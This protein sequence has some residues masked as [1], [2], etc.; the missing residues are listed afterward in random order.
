MG[1][2]SSIGNYIE[3]SKFFEE[4]GVDTNNPLAVENELD[5]L[6]SDNPMHSSLSTRD[7]EMQKDAVQNSGHVDTLNDSIFS[8]SSSAD[9]SLSSDSSWFSSSDSG[10]DSSSS[11][12]SDSGWFSSGDSD[13]D[14]ND[15]GWPW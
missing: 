2:L 10:R 8:S 12:S 6:K 15:S 3:D 14:S 7:F 1:I 13:S 9:T 11:S 5:A 4:K